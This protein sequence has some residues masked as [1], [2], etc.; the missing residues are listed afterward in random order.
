MTTT[1]TDQL[2]GELVRFARFTARAKSMLSSGES[3]ADFSALML[4][5]PLRD[6]GPMRI[7]RLAE[8]KQADASTVSRQAAQLVKT[9]LARRTA[10]PDDGRATRLAITD[11]GLATC[12]RLRD[13]RNSFLS[14]AL[15]SWSAGQIEAFAGLFNEFNSLIEAHL[16]DGSAETTREIA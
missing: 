10:D 9:G 14:E 4:L 13:A 2:A 7:T 5:F 1:A 3:A 15:G 6:E 8:I 16:R 12:A 11:A